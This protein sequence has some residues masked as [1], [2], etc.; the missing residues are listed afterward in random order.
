M[1]IS[2]GLVAARA[3]AA[4]RVQ[5]AAPACWSAR[6]RRSLHSAGPHR[7]WRT[8]GS[9]ASWRSGSC[10][11]RREPPCQV[12]DLSLQL[13]QPVGARPTP[14]GLLLGFLFGL[15]FGFGFALGDL[16][17][18]NLLLGLAFDLAFG[19]LPFSR[20]LLRY[21]FLCGPFLGTPLCLR[22]FCCSSHVSLLQLI[23]CREV[24]TLLKN[25]TRFK[26]LRFQITL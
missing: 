2:G 24:N 22:L 18:R 9:C 6:P 20:A 5:R 16:F 19:H 12:T 3:G 21:A 13:F 11:T 8:R 25:S 1:W 26:I 14:R 7:P 10:R 23:P 4:R 17:P 15:L